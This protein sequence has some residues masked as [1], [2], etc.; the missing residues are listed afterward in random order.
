MKTV[1]WLNVSVVNINITTKKFKKKNLKDM[2]FVE[3]LDLLVP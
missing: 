2:I 3:D 1:R